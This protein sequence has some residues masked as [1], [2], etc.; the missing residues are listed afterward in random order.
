[1]H[2]KRTAASSPDSA[3][4]SSEGT[5]PPDI[6]GCLIRA[7][8]D[9]LHWSQHSDEYSAASFGVLAPNLA[10]EPG[11]SRHLR[12]PKRDAVFGQFAESPAVVQA[13]A[14]DVAHLVVQLGPT[15][16]S[17]PMAE[18]NEIEGRVSSA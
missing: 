7:G 18:P 15:D 16:T 14:R 5:E 2:R 1:M 11:K 4:R 12:K 10:D 3:G 8:W 17:A 13:P 6:L 9:H